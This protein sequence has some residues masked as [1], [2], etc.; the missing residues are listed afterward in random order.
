MIPDDEL[1]SLF[2]AFPTHSLEDLSKLT[3]MP[4][5]SLQYR[6]SRAG[7]AAKL[8]AKRRS[9]ISDAAEYGTGGLV[10]AMEV[11]QKEMRS[12]ANYS[13]ERIQAAKVFSQITFKATEEAVTRFEL[14]RLRAFIEQKEYERLHNT[15]VKFEVDDIDGEEGLPDGGSQPDAGGST[16]GKSHGLSV[17]AQSPTGQGDSTGAGDWQADANVG[18]ILVIAEDVAAKF[19]QIINKNTGKE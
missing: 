14:L 2:L 9:S 15:S 16:G 12:E 19:Q 1:I 13:G 5:R 11:L 4:A 8:A 10:E 6:I 7:F 18:E 17:A 3:G